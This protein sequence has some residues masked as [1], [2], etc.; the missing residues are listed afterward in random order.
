MASQTINGKAFEYA[1]LF[2]FYERLKTITSVSIT[3]T[4]LII[5]PKAFL[6]VSANLNKTL[7]E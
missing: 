7:L 5:Q 3:K 4:N 2:E 1:L 6:I